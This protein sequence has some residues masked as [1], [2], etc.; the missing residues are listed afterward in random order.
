MMSSYVFFV[1]GGELGQPLGGVSHDS[2]SPPVLTRNVLVSAAPLAASL[3][4]ARLASSR[5]EVTGR[6]GTV[7]AELRAGDGCMLRRR[8]RQGAICKFVA[9]AT[10]WGQT[11]FEGKAVPVSTGWIPAGFLQLAARVLLVAKTSHDP[12][13][14][15]S[16]SSTCCKQSHTCSVFPP[17]PHNSQ[18]ES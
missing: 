7:K 15:M 5:R 8:G 4:P 3:L 6:D 13:L 11:H 16:C 18:S 10:S 1:L 14:C 9:A 17:P 2:L 12:C